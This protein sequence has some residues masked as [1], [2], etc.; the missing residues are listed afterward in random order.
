MRPRRP[1]TDPVPGA[2]V[3]DPPVRRSTVGEQRVDGTRLDHHIALN[4]A[5]I[6]RRVTFD[7]TQQQEDTMQTA[8]PLDAASYKQATNRAPALVEIMLE[9]LG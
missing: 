3:A 2:A 6:Y 8:V 9:R 4:K 5:V 7:N 1:L